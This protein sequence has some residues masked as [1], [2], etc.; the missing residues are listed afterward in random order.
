MGERA[1]ADTA[2]RRKMNVHPPL[3]RLR[4]FGKGRFVA[5][6]HARLLLAPPQVFPELRGQALFA[7]RV[8]FFTH[9]Q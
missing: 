6:K 1:G 8:R 4:V 9:R 7:R 3:A 2:V 5:G